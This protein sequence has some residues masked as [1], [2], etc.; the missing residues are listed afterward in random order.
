MRLFHVTDQQ[1]GDAITLK[2]RVSKR[3]KF[4]GEPDTPRICV[5]PSPEKAWFASGSDSLPHFIYVTDSSDFVCAVGVEDSYVTE[6]KWL[7]KDSNFRLVGTINPFYFDD[8]P[9]NFSNIV[10]KLLQAINLYESQ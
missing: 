10:G 6:E 9:D 5:S 3:F 2:P 8:H 7:T 4:L 1:W